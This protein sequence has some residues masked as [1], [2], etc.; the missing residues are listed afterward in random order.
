MSDGILRYGDANAQAMSEALANFAGASLNGR[1]LC[2]TPIELFSNDGKDE[3]LG[4]ASGFFWLHKGQPYLVTN[5]HVVSGRNPFTG[6]RLDR[7]NGYVPQ[8][9]RFHGLDLSVQDRVPG[10]GVAAAL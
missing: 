3:V 8:K 2:C 1:S 6:E 7:K 9:I 10:C 4:A 5:W